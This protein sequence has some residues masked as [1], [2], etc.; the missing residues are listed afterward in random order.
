DAGIVKFN[1]DGSVA[2]AKNF[3]GTSWD[4]LSA[5]SAT[6]DGFVAVGEAGRYDGDWAEAGATDVG[7]PSAGIV[8]F[9][10][11][12]EAVRAANYGSAYGDFNSVVQAPGGFIASGTAPDYNNDK[13]DATLV[14]F[15]ND[16]TI[17][18]ERKLDGMSLSSVAR[19]SNDFAAVMVDKD[20]SGVVTFNNN[21][22][23]GLTEDS[24]LSMWLWVGIAAILVIVL[25]AATVVLN[26]RRTKTY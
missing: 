3:G 11:D 10:K 1:Y 19:T 20:G 21:G 25:V 14:K 18:W 23:M 8:E 2:W 7:F 6:S 24:G 13:Y 5:V 16:L 9:S 12:G 26:R 22:E 17:A 15:N 4:Y